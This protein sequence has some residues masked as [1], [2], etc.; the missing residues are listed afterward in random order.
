MADRIP[1]D[2][3]GSGDVG[4]LDFLALANN[5]GTEG[6]YEQGN[7]DCTG[8]ISFLD[9]LTLANNFGKTASATA[10]VPEPSSLFIVGL[11]G[12]LMMIRR[13]RR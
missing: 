12:I 1:G 5:F 9:F 3:D 4:F 10:A 2:A 8:S 13:H 11:G 7:F 6:T